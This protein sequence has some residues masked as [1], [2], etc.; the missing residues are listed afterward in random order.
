LIEN[1]EVEYLIGEYSKINKKIGWKPMTDI[2]NLVEIM[3]ENDL[4]LAKKEQ[5]LLKEG[6][7]DQ[8]WEHPITKL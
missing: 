8:T 4:K 5:V 3:V 1:N 6:L 7:I 2:K